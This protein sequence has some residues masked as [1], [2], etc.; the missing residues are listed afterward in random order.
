MERLAENIQSVMEMK[1][2]SQ[3]DVCRATGLSTAI[4]S[5]VCSGKTKDPRLSTIVP[6]CKALDVTLE[7]LLS[8]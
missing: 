7:E 1:G 4:V 3:A 6:I 5:L 8:M 2:I